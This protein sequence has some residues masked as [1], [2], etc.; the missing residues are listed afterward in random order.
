LNTQSISD[1]LIR[2]K[3]EDTSEKASIGRNISL[4]SFQRPERLEFQCFVIL[5]LGAELRI[6]V[7]LHLDL[8]VLGLVYRLD[9][10][11]ILGLD[12]ECEQ[13]CAL[14]GSE[15]HHL[16]RNRELG[17]SLIDLRPFD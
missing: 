12:F 16:K 13:E 6:H 7:L 2:Y 10:K 17:S 5:T 3:G 4:I 14:E 11:F 1:S 9:I 8:D 15:Y